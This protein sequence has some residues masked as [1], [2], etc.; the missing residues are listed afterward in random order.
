MSTNIQ[1]YVYKGQDS[2]IE[3]KMGYLPEEPEF[4][5]ARVQEWEL[6]TTV[7]LDEYFELG[8]L[9]PTALHESNMR[10]RGRIRKAV[11]DTTILKY[12]MGSNNPA[13]IKAYIGQPAVQSVEKNLPRYLPEF[14]ITGKIRSRV[15]GSDVVTV[16]LNR[17]KVADYTLRMVQ[18]DF[19]FEN[20]EFKATEIL[21]LGEYLLSDGGGNPIPT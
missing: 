10:I 8:H 13:D 3:A 16:K 7:D 1:S 21:A 15:T 2:I 5:L 9:Y 20:F 6:R 18:N 12:A 17:C 19:I 4:V 11:W 14:S